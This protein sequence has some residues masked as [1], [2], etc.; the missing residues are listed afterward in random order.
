MR[1]LCGHHCST[2]TL[3]QMQAAENKYAVIYPVVVVSS[4]TI[5]SA[6]ST[7]LHSEKFL[8]THHPCQSICR[9]AGWMSSQHNVCLW[10]QKTAWKSVWGT[11]M[12]SKELKN[13]YVE[14]EAAGEGRL[15]DGGEGLPTWMG[16]KE[17]DQARRAHKRWT[18]QQQLRKTFV[19]VHKV[20]MDPVTDTSI[21]RQ[22]ASNGKHCSDFTC[23]DPRGFT[24]IRGRAVPE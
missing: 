14:W 12:G 23:L 13:C 3:I 19:R 8:S 21:H 1:Y 9:E 10:E 18:K 15:W 4:L 6:E 16:E 2:V 7:P 24:G 17:E 11:S 20:T 5:H 22:I